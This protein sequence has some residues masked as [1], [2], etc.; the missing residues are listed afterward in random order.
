MFAPTASRRRPDVATWLDLVPR[1]SCDRYFTLED[2][3]RLEPAEREVYVETLLDSGCC[4]AASSTGSTSPPTARS[5]S[6]TTRP[7]GR[8]ARCFEAKAL[9][10]MKFYALVIWRTRG[11]VPAMLQ[12]VYLGN[13][14]MLRYEPDERDLL[15]TER[16]VEAIWQAI[17]R[18][19]ETGDWRPNQ[20]ALCD[21]CAHQAHLPGLRR[22]PP[23]LPE[24]RRAAP[25]DDRL[26]RSGRASSSARSSASGRDGRRPRR[27]RRGAAPGPRRR[28]SRPRRRRRRRRSSS[29]PVQ[30]GS[31]GSSARILVEQARQ[32]A[33]RPPLPTA[34][35]ACRR[36]V[37]LVEVADHGRARRRRSSPRSREPVL[38][39]QRRAGRATPSRTCRTASGQRG[40]NEQP[41]GGLA[42]SGISP[43]GR[44]RGTHPLR[45]RV[46][47]RR[48]QRL[49][50]RVLAGWRR[51][52]RS[53][54]IS[55][56][57]P[58]YM[59]AIRSQ[60]NFALARSWVM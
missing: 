21:W 27:R 51:S 17:Q 12:L 39:D 29:T 32:V 9:F 43:R 13:G 34:G 50:V 48:Q 46:G 55:T 57:R 54:P 58:R 40:W 16:K 10:Q 26:Q 59:I 47:D 22:H 30:N 14:E 28:G 2:P 53:A 11:V 56:I 3:R 42:A 41:S 7:A 4:C 31:S 18:A 20:S 8:P 23:P 19:D 49:R 52:P 1:R 45:V 37:E 60:K 44:S 33:V 25:T 35:A 38:L 6:S 24:P 36:L 15:A 5:G